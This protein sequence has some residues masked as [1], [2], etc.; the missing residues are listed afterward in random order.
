MQEQ[1]PLEVADAIIV[2]S[3]NDPGAASYAAELYSLNFAPVIVFSGHIL[4]GQ[5][6]TA[7]DWLARIARDHGVPESAILREQTA[8]NM[9]ETIRRSQALLIEKGTV[10]RSIIVI[11]RPYALRSLAAT[12]EAQWA[13]TPAKIVARHEAMELP[14]YSFRHG[15]GETIRGTLGSFQRLRPYAKKGY[16]AEQTIPTEVQEAYD[17]LLRRGHH[18]A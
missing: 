16:L 4:P 8:T 2:A 5:T 12:A 7:A 3:S 13:G 10:P 17:L 18:T 11:D 14:E 6:T 15:R 1:T 9:G